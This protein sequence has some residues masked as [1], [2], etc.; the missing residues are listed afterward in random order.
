MASIDFKSKSVL[1]VDNGM[2]V[3]LAER[4]A[5]DFSKTGYFCDWESSFPDG[6]E[7]VVGAGLPNIEREKYLWSVYRNYDLIVFPDVWRG[8]WQQKMR[9]DGCRVWGSG[10]G[11]ELELSRW[12]T[13]ERFEELGLEK[14]EAAQVEGTDEL[15]AYLKTHPRQYVKVSGFRGL[16]ETFFAENLEMADGQISELEAKHG[17]I[18]KVLPF[19]CEAEIPDAK[20]LGYD[21]YCIDGEF[22]E[23]SLFGA[24]KKDRAYFGMVASYDDL[25][26]AIREANN[27]L[28]APLHEFKY[29]QFFSTEIRETD[30]HAYVIDLTCRHASPAGEV[31]CEMFDNLAEILWNGAD[32]TLIH[33]VTS[34]KYGAQIMLFAEWAEDH[35]ELIDFPEE[36]RDN[37]KLYNHSG[38]AG[39]DWVIQQVAKM[40]Q[41][42]SVVVLGDD[43]DETADRCK[44]IAIQVHGFDLESN[45]DALDDAM[46]EMEEFISA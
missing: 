39:H 9:A 22:P 37:V 20:E 21:G 14:S 34:K 30:D 19:I 29:R 4:L 33:P 5:K 45:A 42:G 36:I 43:P 27:S 32:G 31:Y 10:F 3:S 40:K 1:I 44:E 41:V 46:E 35:P 16:G 38:I 18:A 23:V 2:F 26:E 25:P 12:K 11:S 8:D 15:R 17:P 7:L 6:H 28:W 24:E 13:R